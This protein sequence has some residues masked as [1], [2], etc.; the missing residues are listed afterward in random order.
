MTQTVVKVLEFSNKQPSEVISF[1]FDF[2][3]VLNTGVTLVSGSWNIVAVRPSTAAT[4]GML[5]GSPTT[6][7]TQTYQLI[8]GGV[9]G[10]VYNL[11]GAAYTTDGQRVA[12]NALLFVTDNAYD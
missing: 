11:I 12:E 8:S 1:G 6:T 7:G 4:T 3:N 9:T 2:K 10:S 5:L